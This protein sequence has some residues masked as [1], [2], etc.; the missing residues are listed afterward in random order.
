M[1]GIATNTNWG[2]D[3]IKTKTNY[4]WNTKELSGNT[5]GQ[6]QSKDQPDTRNDY[7]TLSKD[8]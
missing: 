6:Q 2:R 4:S 8:L 7:K 5:K 3:F 1:T